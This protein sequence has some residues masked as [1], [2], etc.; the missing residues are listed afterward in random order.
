MSG[1]VARKNE[2]P[3]Q[4]WKVKVITI[5][6]ED[7]KSEVSVWMPVVYQKSKFVTV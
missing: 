7:I 6:L 5:I 1:Q 2:D 4:W 3:L